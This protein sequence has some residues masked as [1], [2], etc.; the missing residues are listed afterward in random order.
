MRQYCVQ[1]YLVHGLAT[2]CGVGLLQA[3]TLIFQE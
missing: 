1:K 2:E 3:E